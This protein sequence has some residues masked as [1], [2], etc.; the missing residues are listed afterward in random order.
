MTLRERDAKTWHEEL[1]QAEA[2]KQE[3]SNRAELS[4]SAY[5]ADIGSEFFEDRG[6][7]EYPI[8]WSNIRTIRPNLFFRR[9]PCRVLRNSLVR[10][11][12]VH[13]LASE[14]LERNIEKTLSDQSID[15]RLRL[16]I[17]HALTYGLGQVWLRYDYQETKKEAGYVDLDAEIAEVMIVHPDDFLMSQARYEDEIRWVARAIYFT[18]DELLEQFDSLNEGDLKRFTWGSTAKNDR[19]KSVE[20]LSDFARTKVWE[21]WSKPEKKQYF[22]SEGVEKILLEREV[23]LPERGKRLLFRDFFPCPMPLTLGTEA[24]DSVYPICDHHYYKSQAKLLNIIQKKSEDIAR[25]GLKIGGLFDKAS[26]EEATNLI[27]GEDGGFFPAEFAMSTVAGGWDAIVKMFPADRYAQVLGFLDVAA[28]EQLR[29]LYEVSGMSDVLRGMTDPR[30]TATSQD[31]KLE[32]ASMRLNE[33][34]LA[35]SEFINK[36]YEMIGEIVSECFSW[37]T[38]LKNAGLDYQG[39]IDTG[40]LFPQIDPRFVQFLNN[41]SAQQQYPE[42]YQQFSLRYQE[43]QKMLAALVLVRDERQR[44]YTINVES[45]AMLRRNE[46]KEKADLLQFVSALS[47]LLNM[48]S[49]VSQQLPMAVPVFVDL[50]MG[51]VRKYDKGKQWE[52]DLEQGLR[53]FK[54]QAQAPPPSPQPDPMLQLEQ[55]KAQLQGQRLQL[56]VQKMQVEAQFK[57]QASQREDYLAGLKGQELELKVR[58]QGLAEELKIASFADAQKAGEAEQDIKAAKLMLESERLDDAREQAQAQA[59]LAME[60]LAAQQDKDVLE[61]LTTG[62]V[63]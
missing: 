27:D 58:E 37:Q 45:E 63:R 17:T 30:E 18:R 54:Q 6:H 33:Q 5:E 56:E 38:L 48:L 16:V 57:A 22:V 25:K 32:T 49:S 35:V 41:P 47:D 12:P 2:A 11:D 46:E 40:E 19:R 39:F 50:I 20:E 1:R 34:R 26:F 53:A 10:T 8:H 55:L 36:I 3:F 62:V 15:K 42:Q 31:I 60:E 23:L 59:A 13:I 9:P 43:L 44:Y 52:Q 4:V 28:Q 61:L 21:I 14:I 24:I 51:V 29:R 7:A